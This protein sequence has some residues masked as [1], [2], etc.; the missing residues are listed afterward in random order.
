VDGRC[1]SHATITAVRIMLNEGRRSEDGEQ[2]A[3]MM[4][5]ST[6]M[7]AATMTFREAAGECRM[8]LT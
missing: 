4:T 6:M 7:T 3:A 8:N 5:P 1:G 2:G